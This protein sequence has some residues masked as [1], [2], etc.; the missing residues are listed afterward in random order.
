MSNP[1]RSVHPYP[2]PQTEETARPDT[3]EMRR[4]PQPTSQVLENYVL[5]CPVNQFLPHLSQSRRI[6]RRHRRR[7]G[8]PH[9]RIPRPRL[10]GPDNRDSKQRAQRAAH[11]NRPG[12]AHSTHRAAQSK[13]NRT[14]NLQPDVP[15]RHHTSL[16]LKVLP[17]RYTPRGG[18]TTHHEQLATSN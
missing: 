11:D 7:P 6:A 3:H 9:P 18:G 5:R 12:P 17:P 4:R 14:R 10:R 1:Y 16:N 13:S 15:L 8:K 2:P